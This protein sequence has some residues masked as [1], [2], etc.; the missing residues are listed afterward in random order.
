[1]AGNILE[2]F[3]E[4]EGFP[5]PV[6]KLLVISRREGVGKISPKSSLKTITYK[7]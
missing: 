3:Q 1:M 6:S 4:Y 5:T 2:R 7:G